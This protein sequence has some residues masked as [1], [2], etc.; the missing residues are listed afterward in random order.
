MFDLI[1]SVSS[2]F[3]LGRDEGKKEEGGRGASFN[4]SLL[5]LNK[6]ENANNCEKSPNFG[7]GHP[8]E[9]S[10]FTPITST[11]L[12]LSIISAHVENL[13]NFSEKKGF[14]KIF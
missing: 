12:A 6:Q 11:K 10:V 7:L 4:F 5:Y 2:F 9:V 14:R 13:S 8:D 1:T 3:L